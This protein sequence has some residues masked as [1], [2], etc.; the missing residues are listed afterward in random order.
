MPRTALPEGD[1]NRQGSVRVARTAGTALVNWWRAATLEGLCVGILWWI[2]LTLLH[3]PLAPLWAMI[4]ALAAFIPHL[5]GVLSV[6]GPV[7]AVS[8]SGH[9]FYRLVWVLGLYAIIVVLDQLL[10]QPLLLKKTTRVPIW[11]SILFPIVLGIVIPFWGVLLAPPLLAVFYAF[12]K[13]RALT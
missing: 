7:L 13:P 8:F 11:A 5:G 12:R 4:A 1:G 2:G 9:D 3:V 10:I 6:I